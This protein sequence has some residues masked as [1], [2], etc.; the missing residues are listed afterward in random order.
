[1][2]AAKQSEMD[3]GRVLLSMNQE[4]MEPFLPCGCAS[5]RLKSQKGSYLHPRVL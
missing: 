3:A 1:M 2:C 5:G 4:L